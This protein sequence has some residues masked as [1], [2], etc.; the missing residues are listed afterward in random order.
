MLGKYCSNQCR[1]KIQAQKIKEHNANTHGVRI[2]KALYNKFI[3]Y[4]GYKN[5][6]TKIEELIRD[7]LESD[8][9]F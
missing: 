9:P 4:I 2:D 6:T 5:P 1:K 8:L 3:A 7:F